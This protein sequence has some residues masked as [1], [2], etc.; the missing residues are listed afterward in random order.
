V[1]VVVGPVVVGPVVV[2]PVVTVDGPVVTVGPSVAVE[3]VAVVVGPV[4]VVVVVVGRR[5]RFFSS[6][7]VP[8]SVTAVTSIVSSESLILGA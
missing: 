6:G 3:S 5:G 8:S 7:T 2:G 4:V 1:P